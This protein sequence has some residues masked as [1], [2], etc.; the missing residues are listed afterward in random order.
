MMLTTQYIHV[1]HFAY[2]EN[3]A[4]RSGTNKAQPL[5]LELALPIPVKA[6]KAV[7]GPTTVKGQL[8]DQEVA[9]VAHRELKPRPPKIAPYRSGIFRCTRPFRLHAAGSQ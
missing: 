2:F 4:S 5:C 9:S 1:V 8:S 6:E 7:L 3:E